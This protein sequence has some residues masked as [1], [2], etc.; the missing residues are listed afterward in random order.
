M[1]LFYLNFKKKLPGKYILC[2][3]EIFK[4]MKSDKLFKKKNNLANDFLNIAI[5]DMKYSNN[6]LL[7]DLIL[8]NK[9]KFQ[10]LE[11]GKEI[12]TVVNKSSGI[13]L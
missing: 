3:D 1:Y 8:G 12:F 2:N 13:Y 11:N 7:K 4:K 9:I 6:V 10:I 5:E